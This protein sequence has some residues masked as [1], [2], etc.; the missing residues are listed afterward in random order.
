MA[1]K[2]NAE[3]WFVSSSSGEN[4]NEFF[5]RLASLVF[6]NSIKHELNISFSNSF[7]T[8]GAENQVSYQTRKQ[9]QQNINIRNRKLIYL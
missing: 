4:V 9:K 1:K 7:K 3:Y 5:N 6:N 2:L 8:I